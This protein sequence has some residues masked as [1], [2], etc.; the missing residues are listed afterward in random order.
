MR[1]RGRGIWPELIAGAASWLAFVSTAV[2]QLFLFSK[3]KNSI[4]DIF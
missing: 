3:A 1:N 2:L 4:K